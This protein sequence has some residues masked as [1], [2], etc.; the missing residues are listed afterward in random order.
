MIQ[1]IVFFLEN[2][3]QNSTLFLW[4]WRKELNP[5]F[6]E[7]DAMN[8]TVKFLK[9]DS[10]NRTLKEWNFFWIWLIDLNFFFKK[11]DHDSKKWTFFRYHSKNWTLKKKVVIQRIVFFFSFTLRIEFFQYDSQNWTLFLWIW[12]KNP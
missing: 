9:Y 4:I 1:R 7:Y 6:L 11:K 5:L 8:W 2:D 12:P 10:K 3:W